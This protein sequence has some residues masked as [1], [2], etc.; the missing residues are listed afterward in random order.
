[1][2]E[3]KFTGKAELYEKFRPS[4]PDALIDFL[5]EKVPCES[6]ADI[7]AGTGKFTRC[8]LHKPWKV[9]AV[10]P[11]PDMRGK[12]SEIYGI[13]VVNSPAENTGL[14]EKSFG[15]VTAAQAFHWFDEGAFKA[16]CQRILNDNG[17]VAV[18]WNS[19][20]QEDLAARQKEL[21]RKYSSDPQYTK[22]GHA[23]TRSAIA[24]DKFLGGYFRELEIAEFKGTRTFDRESFIGETLS[25]SHAPLKGEPNYK[26]FLE[27]LNAAFSE[28]ESGGKAVVNCVTKCYLGRF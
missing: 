3:R 16:E 5:Y 21:C 1:M 17:K 13:T 26:P 23:G 6:V 11:N 12:L 28:F 4:Y 19:F 7:G 22:T 20:V 24:G 2:N 25:R 27:E 8:L 9:T 14:P 10:E 18:V 15:L